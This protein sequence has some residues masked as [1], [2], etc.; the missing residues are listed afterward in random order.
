MAKRDYYEVLGVAR[1]A[2]P[3][4]IKKAYRK[5]A[6]EFHPDRNPGD[7]T[8]EEKFKEASEAYEVLSDDDKRAAYDRFGHEGLRRQGFE[9]FSGVED[10]FSHFS[11]L[12]GDLFGGARGGGRGRAR[13]ADLRV[14]VELTF[15]EAVAGASKAVDVT[16][17]VGCATCSGSGARPGT[18]PERCGTCGGRGQV[19]HQQGFFMIGTTCPSC[20]GEGS[21]IRDKCKD[22][23]GTGMTERGETLT[24]SIPAGVDDGQRLRLAGKGEAAP[25]GGVP[26]NLYVDIHVKEDPRFKRDGADVYSMAAVSYATAALGGSVEVATLD[27]GVTGKATLVIEPGTQP[28]TVHVR[29]GAGIPRLDGYGRGNHIVEITVEVPRKLSGRQREL[30]RELAAI[31][32]DAAPDEEPQ[33][34]KRSFFGRKK[35]K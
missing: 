22:C 24:I 1:N 29:K 17:H 21:I 4:E 34:E 20:R 6:M 10:I 19:L 27:D 30:L 26:G 14:G 23:R 33:E 35:R 2:E 11:D 16:R 31:E 32:G 7:K 25:R 18:A 8:C 12:F 13:G 5:L 9:G 3:N 15:A 28:G